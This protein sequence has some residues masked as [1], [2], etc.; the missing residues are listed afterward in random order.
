M[1][2][3]EGN[4]DYTSPPILA[5]QIIN[6]EPLRIGFYILDYQFYSNSVEV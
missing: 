1:I 4:I 2:L 6:L 5:F 3:Q